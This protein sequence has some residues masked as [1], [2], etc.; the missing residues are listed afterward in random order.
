MESTIFTLETK[1]NCWFIDYDIDQKLPYKVSKD[2]KFI[3]SYETYGE[4]LE[5]IM[6]RQG[7]IRY[8]SAAYVENI[9]NRVLSS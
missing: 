6:N 7:G 1:N 4:A 9:G 2:E 3:R 8:F 5:Y